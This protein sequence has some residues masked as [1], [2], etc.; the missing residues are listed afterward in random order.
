MILCFIFNFI[1]ILNKGFPAELLQYLIYIFFPPKNTEIGQQI[2][3]NAGVLRKLRMHHGASRLQTFSGPHAVRGALA[4]AR[5]GLT[6]PDS[7]RLSGF[8]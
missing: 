7:F 3:I 6:F 2:M 4:L 5:I 8:F 1:L